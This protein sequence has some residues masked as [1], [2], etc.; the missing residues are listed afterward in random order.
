MEFL[1]FTT[2][3]CTGQR[4]ELERK[5]ISSGLS[6]LSM[7][8]IEHVIIDGYNSLESQRKLD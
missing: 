2:R 4:A 3:E 5:G 7:I 8:P 6:V 1:P